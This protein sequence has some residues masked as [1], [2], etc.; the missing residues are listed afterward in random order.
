MPSIL[1]KYKIGKIIRLIILVVVIVGLADLLSLTVSSFLS[2]VANPFTLKFFDESILL[3][4][5]S[6]RSH[7]R[8]PQAEED[9]YKS[10]FSDPEIVKYPIKL[11]KL[12]FDA[13]P[14][15]ISA[16]FEVTLPKDHP[17]LI[18]ATSREGLIYADSLV[19]GAL[20]NVSVNNT[21]LKF[22]SPDVV[23]KEGDENSLVIVKSEPIS[24]N[25][26]NEFYITVGAPSFPNQLP[27]ENYEV[28]FN[29]KDIRVTSNALFPLNSSTENTQYR[30]SP[31]G[32]YA[33]FYLR[34]GETAPEQ[35]KERTLAELLS[36]NPSVPVLGWILHGLL[37]ASPF[38]LFLWFAQRYRASDE[39]I[40][41]RTY[42]YQSA[43]LIKIYLVFHTAYFALL[44]INEAY[45][46]WGNPVF[47]AISRLQQTTALP[48]NYANTS[49]AYVLFPLIFVSIFLWPALVR[50]YETRILTNRTLYS[51]FRRVRSN[52]Y[53]SMVTR[54][55]KSTLKGKGAKNVPRR[56][57]SKNRRGVIIKLILNR[58]WQVIAIFVFLALL[59]W[60]LLQ[61]RVVID[62]DFSNYSVGS[63]YGLC[64]SIL[65]LGLYLTSLWLAFELF[66]SP[67]ALLVLSSLMILILIAYFGEPL[68]NYT[69]D[70]IVSWGVF[71]LAASILAYA[72]CK[73]IYSLLTGRM[74][75]HYWKQWSGPKRLLFCLAIITVAVSSRN[76]EI[77]ARWWPL[78]SLAAELLDLFYL[79]LIWLL[80]TIL[81][82]VSA[83]PYWPELPKPVR[84]AGVLFAVLLFFSPR[85][86]L[87]WIPITTIVG[88]F[89]VDK[90]LLRKDGYKNVLISEV[91]G[92][93]SAIIQGVIDLNDT[94]RLLQT[95]K[96]ELAA[97]VGKGETDYSTYTSK[98]AEVDG[99]VR[100]K[101]EELMIEGHFGKDLVLAFGPTDS[102]WQNG[103]SGAFYSSLFSIPWLLV[104]LQS[105][106]ISPTPTDSYFVLH[107]LNS[108]LLFIATWTAY[109]FFFGYFYPYIRGNNGI[110]KGL[111]LYVVL[112]I[113]HLA[114][115]ALAYPTDVANWRSFS[116]W[117]LQLLIHF[118]LLGL[119]AGDF[120]TLR[121]AKF[122]FRHLLQ[123]YRLTSLSAWASTIVVA[124]GAAATTLISSGAAE[125]LTLALKQTGLIPPEL[126]LPTK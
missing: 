74:F 95:L 84:H 65:L 108:L 25:G 107:L 29:T 98:V 59:A 91:K 42:M 50:R 53:L 1:S 118:M 86:W 39:L 22:R 11:K 93:L 7:I 114:W 56:S 40:N 75:S 87:F 55:D 96:K 10:I 113:P 80:V 16:S 126:K 71:I 34:T 78:W 72:F 54:R 61:L 81:R 44:A 120:E 64:F 43:D 5:I 111:S 121:R 70:L 103:E 106:I 26:S 83:T 82:R 41:V 73:L 17:L 102:P 77:P 88:Y 31:G 85:Q 18:K 3:S 20:A 32:V 30:F 60:T 79:A 52:R 66:E 35:I 116:F 124:V 105:I 47:S 48:F 8:P 27:V 23:I 119:I 110:R 2:V 14:E 33:Y 38:L 4:P 115:N 19:S 63:F 69:Y 58:V 117:Q 99:A 51:R 94:E 12:V 21:S 49:E 28:L 104:Y 123:F 90:W 97:K 76:W 101:A 24:H 6:S 46:T 15:Q 125:V 57:Q 68:Q 89:L 122:R 109:G 13:N 100:K 36:Q 37:Q 112:L 9:P 92:R 62:I 45:G 67:R